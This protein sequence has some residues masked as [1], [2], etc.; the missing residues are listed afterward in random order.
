MRHFK[1]KFLKLE[2]FSKNFFIDLLI[3]LI[4]TLRMAF[5]LI[6]YLNYF[7]KK[8]IYILVLFICCFWPTFGWFTVLTFGNCLLVVRRT[9]YERLRLPI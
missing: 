5:T 8:M 7:K 2:V 1:I 4:D 9:Y 6:F 3:Y